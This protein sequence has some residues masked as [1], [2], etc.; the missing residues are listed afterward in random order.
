VCPWS[1][2]PQT[3]LEF[4]EANLCA[5]LKEPANALSNVAYIVV[6]LIILVS[7]KSQHRRFIAWIGIVSIVTGLGSG[8]Y[9]ASGLR[10]AGLADYLGMFL[11]TGIMT[12]LNVRRWL[13]PSPRVLYT[14]FW[15]TTGSLL[16][17]SLLV[18]GTER[19]VYILAMPCCVIEGGLFFRDKK[20]TD[21]RNYLL[22]WLFV[23]VGVVFWWLDISG[24]LCEPDNHWLQSHALWHIA[25]AVSFYFFYRFYLQFPKAKP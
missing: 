21:Y 5:W 9:H 24:V 20:I 23:L 7:A 3:G 4:C 22:A 16:A 12:A 6:G 19:W 17:L 1:S 14:V 25:T 2:F 13:A 15:G 18:P 11:G 10:I 8:F